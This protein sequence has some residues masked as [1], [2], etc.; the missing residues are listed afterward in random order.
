VLAAQ[1]PVSRGLRSGLSLC[2]AVDDAENCRETHP[3]VNSRLKL[4]KERMRAVFPGSLRRKRSL[5][6]QAKQKTQENEQSRPA[7]SVLPVQGLII[8]GKRQW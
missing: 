5:R 6:Y 4:W 8:D 3:A 7:E 2:G 1:R